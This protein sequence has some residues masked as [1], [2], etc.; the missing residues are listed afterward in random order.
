ME[1]TAPGNSPKPSKVEAIKLASEYLK[2]FV[3]DEVDNGLTH[4]SEDAATDPQVPRLV[5]AGRSRPPH[6]AEAG[7]EGEGLPV[8]G[9]G[10]DRRREADGRPVPGL[11]RAGPDARQRH[12]ADHDPP[13]VPAPRRP[14]GRPGRDDPT[15]QRDRCSRPWRPAATSSATCSAARPRSTTR[16]A[17]NFKHDAHRWAAHAAP[18]SSSY[19]DIWLDGEKIE[20]AAAGRPVPGADRRRRPGRAALRQGLPAAQ[21]Q[22]GLRLSRRQLHRHPRQRPGLSGDRRGRPDRRLQ[23]AG[24]RRPGHDPERPEDVP[25][26]G[27]AALLRRPRQTCSRSARPC[28]RSSATSATAPTASGPGSSTSSTTGACPP[29]AP[30]SRNTSAIRS[31]TRGRSPSPTSTTTWAG[32]S[33]ATASSSWAS[34]SRTAG[35]RTRARSGSSAACGPSSRSTASRPG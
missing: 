23:R 35:S 17:T 20:T 5:P 34:R 12:A 7:E 6:P 26:P 27:R 11:P 1:P 18:R 13:G 19:W 31:P 3:A 24:R 28:S 4:F 15:D 32:T 14:E 16:S 10:P 2:T 8:H 9:A 21:V 30:R 33:R 29:S 22:D 25:V